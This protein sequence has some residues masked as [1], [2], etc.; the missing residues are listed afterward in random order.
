MNDFI[1]R[2]FISTLLFFLLLFIFNKLGE[3]PEPLPSSENPRKEIVE[4]VIFTLV[5]ILYFF[6]YINILRPLVFSF[7]IHLGISTIVL[8]LIPLIY[9]RCRDNWKFKDYKINS[10]IR[11]WPIAFFSILIFLYM[12]FYSPF[13]ESISW[14]LLIIYFYSNAF[15]EEFLF[16]GVIQS[17]LERALGQNIAVFY[18]GILFM[19][20][21]LPRHI[22]ELIEEG[23]HLW[24]FLKLGLQLF[25]GIYFGLIYMKTRNIWIPT[26][27][28]YLN[29]W[30]GSILMQFL[31]FLS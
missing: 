3:N 10:K 7:Y 27:C 19:L 20:V 30:F 16:R 12:G 1:F 5:A 23:N 21:H 15:L 25:N 29:N 11:N 24:F 22:F 8:L 17:K 28:H 26:I 2:F 9:T 6:F 4:A 31:L 13:T 14:Y 18:Q